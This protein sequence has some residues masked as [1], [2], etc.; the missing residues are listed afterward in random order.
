MA[1]RVI[2]FQLILKKIYTT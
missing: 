1:I 2:L